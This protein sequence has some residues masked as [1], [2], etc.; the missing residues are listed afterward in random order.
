MCITRQ[1]V[2]KLCRRQLFKEIVECLYGT[3]TSTSNIAWSVHKQQCTRP[4]II[5]NEPC[6]TCIIDMAMR[7]NNGRSTMYN[8]RMRY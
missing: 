7:A 2:C 3:G 6:D 8:P 4:R 5:P 1:H